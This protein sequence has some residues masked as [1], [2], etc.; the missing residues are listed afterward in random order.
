MT[1]DDL[2][3]IESDCFRCAGLTSSESERSLLG[4]MRLNAR[5]RHAAGSRSSGCSGTYFSDALC[6]VAMVLI[7]VGTFFEIGRL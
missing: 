5:A 7:W 3:L 4:E 6:G 2:N 1:Q